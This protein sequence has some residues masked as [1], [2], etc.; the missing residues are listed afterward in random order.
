MSPRPLLLLGAGGLARE[1]LA[2][3]RALPQ[4]WRPLGMLDDDTSK[5]GQQVDGVPVLGATSLVHDHPDAAV[6][7]CVASAHRP[8]GRSRLVERLNLPANRWASLVHP[9]ASL[10]PGVELGAGVVLLAGVVITAP[11]RLGG[12]VVAMP[13]VLLTHDD[14]VADF[15]TFAGR[16]CLGGGVSVG[17]AAYLGQGAMV[18]EGLSIGA[19]AVV[20]MGSVVLTDVPAGQTWVGTPARMIKRVA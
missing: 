15:V 12:H 3:A 10:A 9:A 8:L 5:H 20:G 6:L 1:V 13:H 4:D 16:A 17:R 19:E 2:A 7:A 11:I 14:E 18:R